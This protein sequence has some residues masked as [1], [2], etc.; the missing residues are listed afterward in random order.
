VQRRD[1]VGKG[2]YYAWQRGDALHST[3]R[4]FN[5]MLVLQIEAG[6]DASS[7]LWPA[8]LDGRCASLR[9]GKL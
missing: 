9:A 4:E 8:M 3:R 1:R 2:R 5:R 7:G 6:K